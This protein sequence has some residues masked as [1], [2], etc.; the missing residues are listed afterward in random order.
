M[1]NVEKELF[2]DIGTSLKYSN[3]STEEWKAIRSLTDDRSI[4]IEK[5]KKVLLW[6]FGKEMTILRKAKS[7]CERVVC[8][9]RLI[10]K[11]NCYMS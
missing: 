2:E 7:N 3:F 1:S 8:I 9:R 4:V 11:K 6:L 10:L 5:W